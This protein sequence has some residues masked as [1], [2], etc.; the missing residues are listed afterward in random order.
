MIN[1]R[2]N[3]EYALLPALIF[4]LAEG[5]RPDV[6]PDATEQEMAD[7]ER[8]VSGCAAAVTESL[9]GLTPKQARQHHDRV[10]RA[11]RDFDAICDGNTIAKSMM[12][13]FYILKDLTDHEY[14]WLNEGTPFADAMMTVIDAL[15]PWFAKNKL[16]RS[17]QKQARHVLAMFMQKHGLFSGFKGEL[18]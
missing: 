15:Q 1:Q 7:Y 16:D 6:A 9:H 8:V 18:T 10:M 11:K 2:R 17:A 12:I 5:A 13:L 4:S 14:L 3:V